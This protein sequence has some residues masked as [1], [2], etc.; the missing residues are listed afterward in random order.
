MQDE[1]IIFLFHIPKTGGTSLREALSDAFGF[2]QGFVHL[3][4]YGDRVRQ[5]RGLK[6]LERFTPGEIDRVR[7]VSG[8]YLSAGF[9]KYFPG[10]DIRRIVLLREPANRILSQYNHAMRNRSKLG[11]KSI[12]FTE[13]YEQ[14]AL[15]KFCWPD[16]HG[17]TLTLEDKKIAIASVGHNYM[18][19]FLLDASGHTDYQNLPDDRLLSAIERTLG[20]FWHIGCIEHLS[21]TIDIL[22][23]LLG[24]SL[25]VGT[26]NKTGRFSFSK[27]SRHMK[28]TE[29]LRQY[30]TGKNR[31]DY[32]TYAKW[33]RKHQ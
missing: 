29:E 3:G 33:C 17:R 24:V 28:M 15:K 6:P 1:S 12:G 4:P 2:N 23:Q 19:K 25:D 18:S 7:V 21:V 32:T 5:E 13:W 14:L 31:V 10:R 26:Q 9:E 8:H 20:T 16:M 30:L 22:Q 27:L 11:L